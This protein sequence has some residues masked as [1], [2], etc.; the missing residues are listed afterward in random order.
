MLYRA[1]HT[2]R[3]QYSETVST[4]HNEVRLKP[5]TLASQKLENFRIAV[6]PSPHSFADR[7][8]YFGNDV[9][10]FCVLEPHTELILTASS[11]V[12]VTPQEIPPPGSTPA[13]E[14]VREYLR[15]APDWEALRAYEFTAESP[16]V[17]VG[18]EYEAY[19]RESFF[20]G[21]PV[22]EAAVELCS[23]IHRDFVYLPSSTTIDTSVAEVFRTRRGV[24]QDFAHVMI[25]M[26]RSL[27]LAARYVSGYLRSGAQYTGAEASHAWVSLFVPSSGWID[28]DPTN[29]VIPTDGHLT[30]A[31]GRDYQDVTPVKG[32]SLGGGQHVVT[33]EV[34]VVALEQ[35]PSSAAV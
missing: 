2:T 19:A 18:R 6:T 24:C 26:L 32:V 15:Q 14:R 23:R 3:Y 33:V 25:A 35:A 31:W 9:R 21:R 28:L 34:R 13:W 8:D 7:K 30:L 10:Y 4:C 5:R 22:L 11:T 12:R 17:P 27:G 1:N 29:R 16:L 20:K